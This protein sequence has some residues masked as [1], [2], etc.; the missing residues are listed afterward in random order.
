[1][2]SMVANTGTIAANTST[3]P[4]DKILTIIACCLMFGVGYLGGRT[5]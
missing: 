1:M 5:Q 2:A 4:L 3:Y